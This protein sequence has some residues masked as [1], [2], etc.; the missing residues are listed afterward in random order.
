MR[1]WHYLAPIGFTCH[2]E[3]IIWY[4][5][6]NALW[7]KLSIKFVLHSTVQE[8][9]SISSHPAS[10]INMFCHN[11]YL[12]NCECP[13]MQL[14]LTKSAAILI[15]ITDSYTTNMMRNTSCRLE[16]MLNV[17]TQKPISSYS[18]DPLITRHYQ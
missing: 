16:L 7:G 6:I 17:W 15:P 12:H 8:P 10:L 18:H 14:F 4:D 9:H 3:D 1:G 5:V 13:C 11:R 2:L